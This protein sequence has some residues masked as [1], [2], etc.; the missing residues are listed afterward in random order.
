MLAGHSWIFLLLIIANK[1]A[2]SWNPGY[3]NTSY[4]DLTLLKVPTLF[5]CVFHFSISILDLRD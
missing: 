2:N 1:N 3:T 4:I 5:F